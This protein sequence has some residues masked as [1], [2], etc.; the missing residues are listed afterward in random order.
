MNFK[1]LLKN[2][3]PVFIWLGVIFLGSIDLMSAEHTSRFIVPF[4][5][6]LKPDISP[7][8]LALIH[9]I[10]RKCA[11]L[12]EYAVLGLL[13]LR[14]AIFMT[15]LKWSLAMLYVS[16]WVACLFVATTD[17]FHQ[18]FVASRG[19]SATDIMID[20]AGA[21]LGLLIG[22]SFVMARSK[23]PQKTPAEL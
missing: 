13:L 6:W 4:L 11:H 18:T 8:A 9:F 14:A 22:A 7:E 12:G 21:I 10:V 3:L 16:V 15:N 1:R 17:E 2:W 20:G 23:R 5:R 19:A